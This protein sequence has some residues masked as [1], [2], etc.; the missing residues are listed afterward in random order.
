LEKAYAQESAH[1]PN[2]MVDLKHYGYIDAVRGWAVLGVIIVHV[3]NVTGGLRGLLKLFV[4][5]GSF[6]VQLF[7]VASALTLAMSHESRWAKDRRP[8][9]AFFT[10]RIFRIAP[11][12]WSGIVFYVWWYGI[13]PRLSAPHGIG[14]ID[15]LTTALFAHGFHP[16]QMNSVV[17]GGWSIAVEMSF[18]VLA[19]ILIG[20][21]RTPK[22]AC[23]LFFATLLIA[24]V[25]NYLN[26]PSRFF[27]GVTDFTRHN[28]TYRWFPAQLPAFALGI[29]TYHLIKNNYSSV[30][31]MVLSL[32]AAMALFDTTLAPNVLYPGIMFSLFIWG[33]SQYPI[34]PIV[35]RCTRNLGIISFS[36]YLVH[37]AV[38]DIV[39]E[40]FGI[41]FTTSE[42]YNRSRAAQLITS[43]FVSVSSLHPITKFGLLL[44]ATIVG[45]VLI[46]SV[47]YHLIEKPGIRA[48]KWVIR[49]CHW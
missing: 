17:P 31:M 34:L 22:R 38:I 16:Y 45:T 24:G 10:R 14:S 11:L 15:I 32:A 35:N 25:A 12:F 47:T 20:F 36:A 6:G 29:L 18:Y 30:G 42:W 8:T 23:L 7:F 3:G 43:P 5:R 40:F 13:T 41:P 37:F 46:A 1:A 4:D 21:A 39:R 48:G 2:P 27:P 19:P 26:L 44:L 33:L 28:F 9:R 49:L